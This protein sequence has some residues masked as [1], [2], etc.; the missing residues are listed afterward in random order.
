M[1]YEML[2]GER[3]RRPDYTLI[4]STRGILIVEV[5]DW[6]VDRIVKADEERF[7]IR[8]YQGSNVPRPQMN[9]NRKCQI[10]LREVREQLVSMPVLRGKDEHLS[11]PITYRL[12]FPNLSRH[13]FND[14]SLV[15]LIPIEYV[16]F[17]EDLA[18]NTKAFYEQYI[19]ILPELK[20]AFNPKQERAIIE[21]LLPDIVIL[22]TVDNNSNMVLGEEA[23]PLDHEQEQIA[24][25]LGE[26]PRLLRGIAGTGKTLIMLYRAKLLAANDTTGKL[27]ILVLCWN[28]SLANYMRQLYNRLQIKDRNNNQVDIRHFAQFAGTFLRRKIDYEE[29]DTLSFVKC[30]KA[31]RVREVDKYDAIYIDEAQDFRR[32]WIQF[33]FHSL[34]KGND[35]K[36]RNLLIAA[37]DAQRIYL[38]RDLSL[39][40]TVSNEE[41]PRLYQGGDLSW[42]KL[43]IPMQGRTKI[44]KT[45][46]R[47]SARV[48]IFAA[49]LLEE[50][51]S[52]N[53]E[54][55]VQVRWSSK[56][57]YDPVLIECPKPIEQ[58]NKAIQIIKSMLSENYDARNVLILYRHANFVGFSWAEQLQQKLSEENIPYESIAE[59]KRDFEW[60]ANTVKISTVH[61][62]KG[63]DSPVVIVVGAETFVDKYDEQ[64]ETKLMY[65]ALTRAREYLVVLHTGRTKGM[66]PKLLYCQEQYA[67]YR[68]K[69]IDNI[70]N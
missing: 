33:L 19:K 38:K 10:Y 44:L 6:G 60:H 1:R 40:D 20:S 29:F 21:A 50:D 15:K 3:D 32:E 66:V 57:G 28:V 31:I 27:R 8:G 24:K 64:D 39:S 37:D 22:P 58:I 18:K 11:V 42:S 46:Y 54:S 9:P 41:S 65:V 69:I 34:L 63:M 4:D 59:N 51:A 70:E 68:S 67:K 30:L 45:V 52:Y 49:Y 53:K 56:G 35:L 12:A 25:S 13:E 23:Y 14:K 55:K 43:G 5:K 7:Y 36:I 2:I 26:G 47:N 48:W 62:A 16:L 17:K 61:S